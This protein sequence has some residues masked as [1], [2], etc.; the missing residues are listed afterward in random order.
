MKIPASEGLIM[1]MIECILR[2]FHLLKSFCS[3][4]MYGARQ[5]N[6]FMQ[7]FFRKSLDN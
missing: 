7:N 3:D 6:A 2:Q 1:T 5:M 4:P